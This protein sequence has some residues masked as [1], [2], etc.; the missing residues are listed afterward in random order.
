[1]ERTIRVL[2]ADPHPVV[3]GGIR[4]FLDGYKDIQVVGDCSELRYIP[5]VCLKEE[6]HILLAGHVLDEAGWK[7]LSRIRHAN[8]LFVAVMALTAVRDGNTLRQALHGGC[9]GVY[10][11]ADSLEQLPVAIRT[12]SQGSL[13]F[14]DK[15]A[16]HVIESLLKQGRGTVQSRKIPAQLTERQQRIVSLVARGLTNAEIAEA[17]RVSQATVALDLSRVY[18]LLGVADRI[19]LLLKVHAEGGSEPLDMALS[20]QHEMEREALHPA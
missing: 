11:K 10:D 13:W 16:H 3:I 12:V 15:D 5:E 19:R 20:T 4:S 1:M 6:A 18:K 9:R 8:G 17:V 2:I 14:R 7:F